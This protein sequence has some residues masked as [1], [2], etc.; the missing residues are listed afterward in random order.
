MKKLSLFLFAFFTSIVLFVP[1]THAQFTDPTVTNL[2]DMLIRFCN[3]VDE[4]SKTIPEKSLYFEAETEV[5]HDIC[6]YIQNSWPT[7]TTVRLNFVDGTITAD[8]TQNKAC[9]PEET[10]E[11]FWQYVHMP[12]EDRVIDIPAGTTIETHAS[13]NFPAWYAGMS[14]GCTTLQMEGESIT[15]TGS[16]FQVLSR[17]GNF[18]DVLVRWEIVPKL[19]IVSQNDLAFPNLW[20]NHQFTIYKDPDTQSYIA[21]I[22]VKNPGNIA[23]KVSITPIIKTWFQNNIEGKLIEKKEIVNNQ[24]VTTPLLEWKTENPGERVNKKVLPNQEVAFTFPLHGALPWRQGN[25]DIT[26]QIE[27]TPLLDFPSTKVNK[28]DL[29]TTSHILKTNFFIIPRNM[30]I[31]IIVILILLWLYVLAYKKRW[32]AVSKNMSKASKKH[33]TSKKK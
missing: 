12:E 23:Q 25:I 21:K 11:N 32:D 8:D 22:V 9:Q 20:N 13:I 6:L 4:G 1:R 27:H 19:D 28:D 14:Y 31:V 30:I 33:K 3:D 26:A 5:D 7:D 17:R 29:K 18:I 10:K 24:I 2:G 15:S 16:M